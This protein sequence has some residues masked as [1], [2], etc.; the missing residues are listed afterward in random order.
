MTNRGL[1]ELRLHTSLLDELRTYYLNTMSLP[2]VRET[3]DSFTVQAGATSLTFTRTASESD[4][5]F[6]HFAFNIPENKLHSAKGWLS[7]RTMLLKPSGHEI[8]HFPAWN[9]HAVYFCD[10]AGNIVEF[11]A[12]HELKNAAPG[13]FTSN[14]VL[15]ASEIGIVVDDVASTVETL[16]SQLGLNEYRSGTP[17]FAAL[18]DEHGLLIVVKRE[19]VW[20]TT[21]DRH[22]E[23]FPTEAL[24]HGPKT[25]RY[26]PAEYPY[27]LAVKE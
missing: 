1:L 23:V 12:R 24:L 3:T 2:I 27:K 22:A 21:A 19:R 15:C 17:D 4:P 7:K 20:F 6:Y 16:K 14:D 10:P 9:A 8:V 13:R 18:G 26:E 25:M 11:I 5:P